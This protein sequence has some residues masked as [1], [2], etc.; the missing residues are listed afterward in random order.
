MSPPVRAGL[1]LGLSVAAVLL[2]APPAA[3]HVSV[4]P[5]T[6][7]AGTT[8]LLQL[9][10]NH[11]CGDSATTALEVKVPE[12]VN[13]VTATRT[14][15]WD[16]SRTVVRLDE[17]VT[18]A[19]GNE[20]TERV[21]TVLFTA[22]EPLASDLR[23]TVELT[24]QVPDQVGEALAFP[25]VQTCEQGENAWIQV[26]QDGQDPEELESPA[27][28]VQVLAPDAAATGSATG[29]ATA[30]TSAPSEVVAWIGFAAG[31]LGLLLGGLAFAQA[32]RQPG[33]V[34]E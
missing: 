33:A 32:R 19:H 31:M 16:V 27:P 11:G 4:T 23:D 14:P 12:G 8:L 28:V 3:A 34:P 17:P 22:T 13:S 5:S 6:A 29:S 18:D 26:A 9:E 7:Q 15:F 10:V 1:G 24:F 21:D 20:L 25:T 30:S 2:V